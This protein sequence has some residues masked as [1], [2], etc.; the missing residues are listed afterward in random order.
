MDGWLEGSGRWEW[1]LPCGTVISSLE[2]GV[3]GRECRVDV[4]FE[5]SHGYRHP[6][7]AW[8]LVSLDSSTVDLGPHLC[9]RL[10]AFTSL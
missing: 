7:G 4:G 6:S 9:P 3:V 10:P 1:T 2:K 5:E 8:P